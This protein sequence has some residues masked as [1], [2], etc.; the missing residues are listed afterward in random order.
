L[1]L[2]IISDITKLLSKEKLKHFFFNFVKPLLYGSFIWKLWSPVP[3][4]YIEY[5]HISLMTPWHAFPHT[6][7]YELF[8]TLEAAWKLFPALAKANFVRLLLSLNSF[9]NSTDSIN[10]NFIN[11]APWPRVFVCFV[12]SLSFVYAF[13]LWN[14][15]TA[16]DWLIDWSMGERV[17][18][19]MSL[20]C[21]KE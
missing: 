17:T 2:F 10:F 3:Y 7:S 14:V 11:L 18:E 4:H 1:I 21:G 9:Y 19:C 13:D 12:G 15:F 20:M 16:N 6:Y 5:T 8:H